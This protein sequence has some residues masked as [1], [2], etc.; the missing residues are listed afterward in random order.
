VQFYHS[1]ISSTPVQQR[2]IIISCFKPPSYNY[3]H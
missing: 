3:L 1:K 2:E